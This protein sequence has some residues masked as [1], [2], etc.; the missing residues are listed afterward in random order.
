MTLGRMKEF[1]GRRILLLQGPVGP[2]FARLS[3]D[4]I[5]AGAYCFKI[6]LNG[7]DWLFS[8]RRA[9]N[10]R[11]R[12]QDWP[13]YLEELIDNLAIDTVMLFGDCR[14]YHL[15]ATEI[16]N[17]RGLKTLVF[18]EGYI[19][20]DYITLEEGGVN[21]HSQIPRSPIFYLNRRIPKPPK[22]KPVGNA[23]WFA[24]L[25]VISYY[26]A[27]AALRPWFWH[28][29]HHRPLT[30]TEGNH[31]LRGFARKAFYKFTEREM[32][33]RLTGALSKRFFLVP[34]QIHTDAQ[35]QIHSDLKSIPDFIKD[36]IGSFARHGQAD[37]FLA[38]KHHPLDRGYHDYASL[39][40]REAA[41]QGVKDRV[42][43]IHDQHLPTLLDHAL[44]VVVINSTVGLSAIHHGVPT[45]ALGA[46]IYDMPGLTYAGAL[47][48]FW[49]EALRFQVD[50]TLYEAFRN[51]VISHTQLNGSF[52]HRLNIP[53]SNMGILWASD[54][55]ILGPSIGP[56]AQAAEQ[57][58]AAAT[59]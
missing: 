1:R 46:A 50:E 28:Y 31:W 30:L 52:Y 4:L 48:D 26:I 43:Y 20:P 7:G 14:A 13:A 17:R 54:S 47:D 3:Q 45:K 11:G 33:P 23:F 39:I 34:L 51:H 55:A 57:E 37:H 12:P 56:A 29:Q 38:I 9:Y 18:E 19:R 35:I 36:V 59:A 27:A 58:P 40:R 53:G 21:G 15:A 10:F 6:N 32:Q 8:Q 5:A 41:R 42:I 24:A 16:A 25:W 44:G 2:F 49:R 22:P